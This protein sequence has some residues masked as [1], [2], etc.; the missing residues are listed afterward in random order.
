MNG[1]ATS[2]CAEQM[3]MMRPDFARFHAGHHRADG[4]ERRRQVDAND[5]VPLLDRELLDRRD[6]LDAGIVDED[7]DGAEIPLGLGH[8]LRDLAR[9]Q[10]VGRIE[11]DAG[12]VRRTG[13]D[14]GRI[15]GRRAEAVEHDIGACR[16]ERLGDAEADAGGRAGDDGCLA[17]E[18]H[19][20]SRPSGVGLVAGTAGLQRF[21]LP[22]YPLNA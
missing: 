21:Y 12:A 10:H 5:G 18:L 4:M 1:E 16:G 22:R 3:L 7:V 2:E 19:G 8:H 14:G 15:V 6:V 17:L 20:L 11:S 13:L 9:A